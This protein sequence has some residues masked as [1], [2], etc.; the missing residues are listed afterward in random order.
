MALSQDEQR[1]LADIEQRLASDDPGLATSLAAFRRPGSAKM[2]RSPRVRIVGSLFTV[3]LVAMVSLTVYAMIPFRALHSRQAP[4]AT[5][6]APAHTTAI[7]VPTGRQ[8]ATVRQTASSGSISPTLATRPAAST[9]S[10]AITSQNSASQNSA[11]QVSPSHPATAALSK[12]QQ[13]NVTAAVHGLM[14]TLTVKP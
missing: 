8:P 3:L 6:G 1:I 13:G 12:S 7:S 5:S 10:A 4:P 9:A 11:S 2:L 14:Q